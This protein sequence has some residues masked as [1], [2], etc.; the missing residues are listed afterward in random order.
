M[1][2]GCLFD[3]VLNGRQALPSTDGYVD[4][5]TVSCAAGHQFFMPSDRLI[6]VGHPAQQPAHG[7]FRLG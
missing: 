3:A 4:H 1:T 6:R 5:G 7:S 2:P